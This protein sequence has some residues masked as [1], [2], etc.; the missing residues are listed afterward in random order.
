M[1]FNQVTLEVKSTP[2][3]KINV[4]LFKNGSIQMTGCRNLQDFINVIII[5]C[6]ELKKKKGVIDTDSMNK[7]IPIPFVTNRD[8]VDITKLKD[9]SIKMIN[10]DF[11]MG[12]RIDRERMYD[13][14]KDDNV[15]CAYEPDKHAAINIKYKYNYE[16][17]V[18]IYNKDSINS[19]KTET[20]NKTDNITILVFE[21][22]KIIITAAKKK[23]HIVKAY[24]FIIS[25]IN[26]HCDDI[27][28]HD[29]EDV[30][31]CIDEVMKEIKLEGLKN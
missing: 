22:G 13:I 9:F 2:T 19:T 29:D 3:K 1:F 18:T 25:I 5:I 12:I 30:L 11:D 24:N 8:D 6:C 4:K 7:I 20:V 16:Q 15:D 14:L 31:E 23:D 10:S 27:Q 17:E 26:T 21:S 28:K